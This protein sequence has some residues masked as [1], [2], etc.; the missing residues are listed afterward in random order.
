[1]YVYDALGNVAMIYKPEISIALAR[2]EYDALGNC[3][4]Y[5]ANDKVNTNP[6]FIGNVNPF[7]W[8]GHYFDVDT[9]L[10]Y[11]NGSYYDPN[12]CSFVDAAP[13]ETVIDNA[14]SPLGLD[15]QSPTCNNKAVKFCLMCK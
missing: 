7:R 1:M 8:K 4:V 12:V 11:I 15:R 3:T 13:L 9:G 14:F 2:Y 6:S 5:D 10:Y